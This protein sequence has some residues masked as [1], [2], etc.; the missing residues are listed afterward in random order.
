MWNN[1]FDDLWLYP[2]PAWFVRLCNRFIGVH[3]LE[4]ILVAEIVG[5]VVFLIGFAAKWFWLQILGYVLIAPGPL[6]L[7]MMIITAQLRMLLPRRKA[8]PATKPR[9]AG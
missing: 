4:L 7:A 3:V 2:M 6:L 1:R 8:P 5:L 9:D